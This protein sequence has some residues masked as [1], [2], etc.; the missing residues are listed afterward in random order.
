[1]IVTY[2]NNMM[3]K[4]INRLILILLMSNCIYSQVPPP[5]CSANGNSG[6][7][8][9]VG[10]GHFFFSGDGS[11][12]INFAMST[13]ANEMDD[14]LVLYIDTGA[15]G[16]NIID[17]TVDDNADNHRIAISN[18]NAFGFGSIIQFPTGFEASY[19][20]AIDVN[21]GGLWSIPS[22]G[23]VGEG[24]LNFITSVNS[25]LSASNQTFYEFNFNWED[26]GLTITD[27]FHFVGVYVSSTG[28]SSDEGYGNGIVNG[29]EGSNNIEFTGYITLPGCSV[30]L[31][32]SVNSFHLIK[33]YY[34][35][36][37]LFVNGINE[38]VMISVYD[39]HGRKRYSKSHHIQQSIMI[40]I[41]LNKHELQFVVIENNVSRQ[42]VKI[43]PN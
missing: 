29:T 24:E 26:I 33:A 8:G 21:F 19:A 40:P 41:A 38:E 12:P 6:F 31:S 17:A 5:P 15:T 27:E 23:N 3:S 36:D 9:A 42:I 13:N 10:E 4:Y 25:S 34:S 32:D 35:N 20:V 11:N 28:Y 30:T 39:I 14:I 37:M 7:G 43:I 1:M 2:G 16:R 22:T 18:S